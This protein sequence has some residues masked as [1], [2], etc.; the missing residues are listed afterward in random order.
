MFYIFDD[1]GR[2]RASLGC[3]TPKR[4]GVS[5]ELN[6]PMGLLT[7]V[8]EVGDVLNPFE[9]ETCLRKSAL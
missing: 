1:K 7:E 6:F 3:W 9:Y 5:Q 2:S 4:Y 8:N